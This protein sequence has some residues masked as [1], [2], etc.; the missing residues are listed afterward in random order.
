MSNVR[1]LVFEKYKRSVKGVWETAILKAPSPF[2]EAS[3]CTEEALANRRI[4][5]SES[6]ASN[7]T[8]NCSIG[9]QLK[10]TDH[11][12]NYASRYLQNSVRFGPKAIARGR[13]PVTYP[14]ETAPVEFSGSEHR[15]M[16]HLSMAQSALSMQAPDR[17][18]LRDSAQKML[19]GI[20]DE[21]RLKNRSIDTVYK[22]EAMIA[23]LCAFLAHDL[24]L[25]RELMSRVKSYSPGPSNF[26]HSRN[27]CVTPTKPRTTGNHF[28]E[29]LS[30]KD[31]RH[32]LSSTTGTVTRH[33][34]K[35]ARQCV[36]T[37]SAHSE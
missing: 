34:H 29:S 17:I 8:S 36:K 12:D 26:Q 21:K 37:K 24:A 16:W 22:G 27:F 1:D 11:F 28:C 30:P 2:N 25:A 19:Q 4:D 6:L 18:L 7:T 33:L 14:Y 31:W 5:V 3:F 15:P 10:L 35:L 13:V 20:D 23:V 32:S 9:L